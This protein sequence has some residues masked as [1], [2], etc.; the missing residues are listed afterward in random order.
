MLKAEEYNQ[1]GTSISQVKKYIDVQL[2]MVMNT[3]AIVSFY[4]SAPGATFNAD[5]GTDQYEL[6]QFLKDEI[7]AT[8]RNR[9][10]QVLL[11]ELRSNQAAQDDMSS[12]EDQ[13]GSLRS[14]ALAK[15]LLDK[16]LQSKRN[17][18]TLNNEVATAIETRRQQELHDWNDHGEKE[19]LEGILRSFVEVV[20]RNKFTEAW[21]RIKHS[22]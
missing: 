9:K 2:R 4:E 7:E 22:S 3:E 1:G 11:T 5:R 18:A 8:V 13:D 19:V 16:H 20:G 14:T 15:D 6:P 17:R 21:R 10:A 12:D